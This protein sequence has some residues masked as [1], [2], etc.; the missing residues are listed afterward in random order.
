MQRSKPLPSILNRTIDR[1]RFLK[2]AAALTAGAATLPAL[3]G[4]NLLGASGRA[5]AAPGAGGYGPIAPVPDLRD[6]VER[7]ALPE[8]FSYRSFGWAGKPMSDGNLTPLAHDGMASFNMPDG[9]IRLVRNH[10]DRNPPGEGSA[11]GSPKYDELG[12]GGT[13]TLEIDPATRTLLADWISITGTIVNCAGG[14]T[15]W[16]SWLT[17]EETNE[18]PT[19]FDDGPWTQQHGYAFDVPASSNAPVNP[20]ALKDLGRFAHE[21]IAVDPGTWIV[22]ETEDN[23]NDSG[24]Y[25]FVPNQKGNLLGGGNLQMLAIDGMPNYSTI[26]G[27]TVGQKLPVAWVDI[28]DPDPTPVVGETDVFDQ[29][30]AE[31]GAR[32]ARLEGCW[33]GNNAIYFNATSGGEV[34]RGQVWEYRPSGNGGGWLT[35]IFESPSINILDRPDNITVSPQGALLLCEDGSGDQFLRAVTQHGGI[36]DF[37]S[38]LQTDHEWA[39]ATFAM[40]GQGDGNAEDKI[41]GQH[42]T[43][44]VN[45]QGDT[46][47]DNP[48]DDGDEGMTFA[49]WGPWSKGAL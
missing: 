35:L 36:F 1:R 41:K 7:I 15:S 47:G 43:L 33:Y 38:N 16:G 49:I 4:L 40:H 8:G 22:Y 6:G 13:T 42:V 19:F 2:G 3:Q 46:S 24:F 30:W 21:A 26:D 10:E 39:G 18:G 29:G 45:R 17:C 25:R 12:G 20:I 9:K 14:A 48:P 34:G 23:G 27:Q 11:G 37:A 44:F 32:F 31:G 28:A 5:Y